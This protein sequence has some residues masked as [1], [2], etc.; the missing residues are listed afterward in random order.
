MYSATYLPDVAYAKQELARLHAIRANLAN[1][2][3]ELKTLHLGVH[4]PL[5]RHNHF[6]NQLDH[7]AQV[8][9]L[10]IGMPFSQP[11]VRQNIQDCCRMLPPA[12]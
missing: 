2:I 6:L 9:M 8:M 7:N 11:P 5:P 10:R 12:E 4:C 1:N 3:I